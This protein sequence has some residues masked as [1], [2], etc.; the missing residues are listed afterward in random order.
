M[1]LEKA[2]IDA[3]QAVSP[4]TLFILSGRTGVEPDMPYCLVTLVDTRTM[5]QPDRIFTNNSEGAPVERIIQ[6]KRSTFHLSFVSQAKD[7]FQDEAEVIQTG[8][9]S[10]RF[11]Q[12]FAARGLGVI[13]A[14][15]LVPM[16]EVENGAVNYFCT[17]LSL[18][19]TFQRINDFA[20]DDIHTVHTVGESEDQTELLNMITKKEGN[21]NG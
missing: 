17:T 2:I 4:N 3:L 7:S 9:L 14:K 21:S 15:T 6:N 12:Q 19:V 16:I 10:S 1:L 18:V 11:I 8:F 5:G 13:L 20:M